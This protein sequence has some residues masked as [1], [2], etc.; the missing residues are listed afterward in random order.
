MSEPDQEDAKIMALARAARARTGAPAGAAVRDLDGRTYAAA[1]VTLPS[2]PLSALRLAVAMA[3]S[4]GATGLE[5]VTTDAVDVGAD[6]LAAVWDLGGAGVPVLL[7]DARGSL[8]R[9][10][11]T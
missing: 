5:A 7:M 6:D 10:L 2:L 4:A 8:T 1:Q 11:L 9:R 3:A